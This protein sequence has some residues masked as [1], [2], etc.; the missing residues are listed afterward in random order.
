M[1]ICRISVALKVTVADYTPRSLWPFAA[2]RPTLPVEWPKL[3]RVARVRVDVFHWTLTTERLWE[4]IAMGL[5][6]E[7][8]TLCMCAPISTTD[9]P[10]AANVV[11]PPNLKALKVESVTPRESG[12]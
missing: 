5:L 4:S 3:P 1:A 9:D 2:A 8:E 11:W 7:V 10:R 6:K 12:M